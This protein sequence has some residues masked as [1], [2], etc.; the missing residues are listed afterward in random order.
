M[1]P[2]GKTP[3]RDQRRF[4]V[5]VTA[6]HLAAAVPPLRYE[7]APVPAAA[8]LDGIDGLG[9]PRH[10]D[11][12]PGGGTPLPRPWCVRITLLSLRRMCRPEYDLRHRIPLCTRLSHYGRMVAEGPIDRCGES[13][14][15]RESGACVATVPL[16]QPRPRT[17]PLFVG[18]LPHIRNMFLTPGGRSG[19]SSAHG[20]HAARK[21]IGIVCRH[22]QNSLLNNE[23]EDSYDRRVL[24]RNGTF[25]W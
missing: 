22:I 13:P 21:Q 5:D 15:E 11:P 23:D 12:G 19:I 1:E 10:G 3:S 7:W 20:R 9:T 24:G 2:A 25:A 18:K 4:A 17:Q 8:A 16:W 6:N 14:S